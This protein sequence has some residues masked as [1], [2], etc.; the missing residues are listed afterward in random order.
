MG[1]FNILFR[2]SGQKTRTLGP[3]DQT[4]PEGYRGTLEHDT[5]LCIGCGTCA[6]VCS[7]GAI[8]LEPRSGGMLW[9]YQAER[10]TYC[11]R[12]AEYCPT[13]AIRLETAV[14]LTTVSI[15]AATVTHHMV[16][17]QPCE[18]CGQPFIPMPAPI[19][20][21][22]LGREV[23]PDLAGLM[24]LCEKCRARVT[25]QRLKDSLTGKHSPLTR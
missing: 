17:F 19:L 5:S 2:N 12:C 3:A 10:C 20:A 18:R 11:A 21:R 13:Q 7:P 22:L 25:S 8:R 6:Y 24:R 1:I 23:E 15:G 16:D 14:P 4:R 9:Q